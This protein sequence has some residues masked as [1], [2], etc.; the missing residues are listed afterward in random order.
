MSVVVLKQYL[1]P[2]IK[3]VGN[4]NSVD[5]RCVA[6]VPGRWNGFRCKSA[7]TKGHN[8]WFCGCHAKMAERVG[9]EVVA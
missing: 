2:D 1:D 9:Y 5:G 4:S 7:A 6:E 8:K 3:P